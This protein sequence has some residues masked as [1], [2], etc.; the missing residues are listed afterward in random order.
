[1]RAVILE[2][3]GRE[4]IARALANVPP[5]VRAEYEQMSTIAWVRSSTDYAVHDAIAAVLGL[6]PLGFH[7]QVLRAA[8]TRSFK[9]IWRILLRLQSDEALIART[10]GIY[11]RTRNVGRMVVQSNAP[12]RAEFVLSE[13][14]RIGL[15]DVRSIGAGLEVVLSLTGRANARV[16]ARPASDG[17]VFSVTWRP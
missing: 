10:P 9:T 17:A 16:A 13:Y 15:R 6:E 5:D 14:P 11:R 3:Y 2:Q 12:G 8:M 1:M 7:E 4:P